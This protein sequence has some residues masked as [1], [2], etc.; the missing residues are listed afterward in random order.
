MIP[1][2]E[3][4]FDNLPSHK[5]QSEASR[6]KAQK[7]PWTQEED[8]KIIQLVAEYGAKNWTRIAKHI[9]DRQGKQC[10]ERWYNHLDPNINKG[11]WSGDEEWILYLLHYCRGNKWAEISK[12]LPGRTDNNIK[13]HWNS[14]MR[15]RV[16]AFTEQLKSNG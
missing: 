7:R 1:L 4:K 8:E 5:P 15:K 3:S 2:G 16:S 6:S 9:P 14:T 10:R 11:D 13:N 12:M